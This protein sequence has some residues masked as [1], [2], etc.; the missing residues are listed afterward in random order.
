MKWKKWIVLITCSDLT[1]GI[2]IPKFAKVWG[3]QCPNWEK[4]GKTGTLVTKSLPY[5]TVSVSCP[6]CLRL[7]VS[8]LIIYLFNCELPEQ[9]WK[10]ST[11]FMA[12]EILI[13]MLWD[14]NLL[15]LQLVSRFWTHHLNYSCFLFCCFLTVAETVGG[16]FIPIKQVLTECRWYISLLARQIFSFVW[17]HSYRHEYTMEQFRKMK[18]S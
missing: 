2:P 8:V 17:I 3:F 16:H 9:E 18:C 5:I 4:S 15:K 11:K 1:T 12:S 7:C 6:Y 10:I 13:L 14:C